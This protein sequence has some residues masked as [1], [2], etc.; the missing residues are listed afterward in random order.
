MYVCCAIFIPIFML[1]LTIIA[2]ISVYDSVLE[3]V[4][5]VKNG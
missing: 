2:C 5:I 4:I 1:L 3:L